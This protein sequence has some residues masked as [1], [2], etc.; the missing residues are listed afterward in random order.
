ML[1]MHQPENTNILEFTLDGD[2]NRAHFDAVAAKLDAMIERH[3]KVRLLEIVRDVG[4]IEPSALWEDLKFAPSHLDKFSHV[5]VVADKTWME[6]MTR[7][8]AAFVPAEV[9]FFHLDAVDEAR[10]WLRDAG[11]SDA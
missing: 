4:K 11:D 3:G 10:Q 7:M 2:F 5:A 8:A 9:R 6:W 1:T